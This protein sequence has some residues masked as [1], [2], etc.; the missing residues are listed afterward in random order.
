VKDFTAILKC[1]GGNDSVALIQWAHEHLRT[2]DRILVVHGDTGWASPLWPERMKAVAALCERY[3]MGFTTIASE[4][5]GQCVVRNHALPNRFMRF[6]TTDLKIKPWLAWLAEHQTE[7]ADATMLCGVRR[8]ESA[9]RAAWPEWV[10]ASDKD[11]GRPLW[12]PLVML[13]DAARDTLVVAAGFPVLPHRSRECFPCINARKRDIA[14]LDEARIAEIEKL[15]AAVGGTLFKPGH[16]CG[17]VGIRQVVA[18]AR[19]QTIDDFRKDDAPLLCDA[20]MCGD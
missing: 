1:S 9:A 3:G 11:G 5:M 18:W 20:G 14:E 19:N 13:D 7:T 6:C 12:S 16:C 17:A 10:E 15:E 4:G 2:S 8:C